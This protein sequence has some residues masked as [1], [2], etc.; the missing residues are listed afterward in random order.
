MAADSAG[1]SAPGRVR[2]KDRAPS[3]ATAATVAPSPSVSGTSEPLATVLVFE[4]TTQLCSTPA[5]ASCQWSCATSLST[6]A[7]T[8]T[9]RQIDR[10][11]VRTRPGAAC[12]CVRV[13]ECTGCL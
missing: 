12:V 3:P 1:S 6:G 4:G 11:P 7:H 5:D 8:I 13:W 2:T 10:A 9:A